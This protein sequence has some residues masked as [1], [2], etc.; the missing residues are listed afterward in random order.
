MAGTLPVNDFVKVTITANH[1]GQTSVSISGRRQTK[2][3]NTQFW[4]FEC[5][6]RS[7]KR[8]DAAQVMAFIAKQRNNL[9]DFDVEMPVFSETQGTVTE[10]L[11][12][13][14]GTS[15]NLTVSANAA[16]NASSVTVSSEWTAAKF[17]SA[18][19]SASAGLKAGDFITFSNHYKT[20]QITDDV[21]FDA[22]GNATINV[23]PNLIEA[24]PNTS[25]I[26]YT[27]VLFHVFLQEPQQTYEF[28]LGDTSSI[29][30]RLQ[31]SF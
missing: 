21:T 12:G 8:E 23:Y 22:S 24:T 10:M 19:V 3:Y 17:A 27:G 26:D 9:L 1:P 11:A 18:G 4:T 6:Y 2:Q 16:I 7:L 31:E 15:A 13:N 25:T 5:D 30:L 20:Y 28:G 14:P 29:S